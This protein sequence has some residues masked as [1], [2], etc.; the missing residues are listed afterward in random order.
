MEVSS[1][2]L[3]LGGRRVS[4]AS[5]AGSTTAAGNRSSRA[6]ALYS[7]GA[8][9]KTRR[10]ARLTAGRR[11]AQ[12]ASADASVLRRVRNRLESDAMSMLFKEGA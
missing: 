4:A 3:W 1:W 5:A 9:R 8:R 11:L 10:A 12:A 7:R 6:N 2:P